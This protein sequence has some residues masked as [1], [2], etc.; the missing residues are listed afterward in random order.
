[1]LPPEIRNIIYHLVLGGH[2]YHVY[3]HTTKS[4]SPDL[5]IGATSGNDTGAKT[6]LYECAIH[7]HDS[8]LEWLDE[9]LSCFVDG[10]MGLPNISLLRVCKQIYNEAGLIPYAANAF[11]FIAPPSFETF[12]LQVLMPRHARALRS[13]ALWSPIGVLP[14][15]DEDVSWKHWTIPAHIHSDNLFAGLQILTLNF[16]IY[17]DVLLEHIE[18]VHGLLKVATAAGSMLKKLDIHVTLNE[19]GRLEGEPKVD[20]E[21]ITQHITSLKNVRL[22]VEAAQASGH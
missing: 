12:V 21:S 4:W 11:I 20:V 14:I 16:S 18:E 17:N 13:I 10:H 9:H 15:M 7:K 5:A 22:V 19:T 2:E 3:T 8:K 6:F 1:M